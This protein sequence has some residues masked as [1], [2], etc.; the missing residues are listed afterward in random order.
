MKNWKQAV[1]DRY[2]QQ[3][4]G[5]ARPY[6]MELHTIRVGDVAIATNDIELFTDFGTQ[7]KSHSPALQRTYCFAASAVAPCTTT[8]SPRAA[9]MIR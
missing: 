8:A 1:V 6:E 7:M 5:T 9:G 2:H 4:A 3:E